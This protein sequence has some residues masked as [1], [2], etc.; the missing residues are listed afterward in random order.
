M[1]RKNILIL[2]ILMI[3]LTACGAV[4]GAAG[5][6][7][8]VS[9]NADNVITVSGSAADQED[10]IPDDSVKANENEKKSQKAEYKRMIKTDGKLFIDTGYVSGIMGRCGNLDGWP[11]EIIDKRSKPKKDGEANFKCEGWQY[12]FDEDTI[13]VCVNDEFCIFATE[14][15][16]KFG[17]YIPEGV[18]QFNAVVESIADG[19]LIVKVSEEPDDIYGNTVTKGAR[20][21]VDI[22]AYDRASGHESLE[23]GDNVKI[24]CRSLVLETDP[25]QIPD[26]YRITYISK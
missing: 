4:S 20:Y 23:A 25:G 5:T 2:P 19:Q 16:D 3:T 24:A 1:M 10:T 21:S 22:E 18:L 12:G 11:E 8:D 14:G 6:T 15:S 17:D 13:D 9:E 7:V 26:V